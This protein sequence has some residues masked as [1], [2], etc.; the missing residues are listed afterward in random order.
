MQLSDIQNKFKTLMLDHPDALNTP[1]ED[2][3]AAFVND[4]IPLPER[5]KV[6]RN[7]IVGSLTDV[8]ADTFPT[9]EKLVGKEFFE[10]M[11]R[12]FILERPPNHG[13][14]NMYGTGF[15]EF[16]ASFGPAQS[17]PYL[18]DVAK[19]ESAI[20]DSYY[21]KDE[22]PLTAEALATIPPDKLADT[23]LSPC[24]YVKLIR[25]NYP[26]TAIREF[27]ALPEEEQGT[28]DLGQGGVRLMVYRS[29]HDVK[30]LELDE[31]K[32]Y[33]MQTLGDGTVL[34]G[35]VLEKEVKTTPL[36]EVA[37]GEG[38][39][40]KT[41]SLGEAVEKTLEKYPDFDFQA[42]LQK[43]LELETFAALPTNTPSETV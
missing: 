37:P 25:S 6:Y 38:E 12:S 39:E 40:G 23:P 31:D 41:T 10:G 20:N 15:D 8:M 9:I 32:F 33:M 2:F 1:D 36:E 21:A 42:F 5:L 4:D 28:L 27:C 11:A 18:P 26:L 13:C 30:T 3:A 24:G 35:A 7:N 19:L 43:H 14:L 17:L 16:I 34:G 29:G 22:Q